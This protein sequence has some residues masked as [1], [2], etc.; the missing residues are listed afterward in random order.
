MSRSGLPAQWLAASAP[1]LP[2]RPSVF[3]SDPAAGRRR[4]PDVSRFLPAGFECVERVGGPGGQA[5]APL[6]A[7]AAAAADGSG[8]AHRTATWKPHLPPR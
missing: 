8:R 7:A 4:F 6:R 2:G 5:G 3:C 1:Q